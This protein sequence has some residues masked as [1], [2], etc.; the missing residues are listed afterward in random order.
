MSLKRTAILSMTAA[1]VL[2]A[3]LASATGPGMVAVEPEAN[4]EKP[5]AIYHKIVPRDTLWD[6]TEHYLKDPF[7][8]PNVWK[9]NPY[10]RNPHLIYPGNTVKLTPDGI[11]VLGPEDMLAEG[12]EKV[13]LEPGQK[14]TVLEP[15]PGQEAKKPVVEKPVPKGPSVKDHALGRSGFVTQKELD[16]SGA[17]VKPREDK[18]LMTVEDTVF[19]SF[20][21]ASGVRK[22]G[23]YTVYSAGRKIVHPETGK[24]LGYEINILGSLKV[25]KDG[26]TVEAVIDEA[27]KE[28]TPGA[29]VRP[30]SEPVREVEITRAAAEVSGVIVM[31]L[32]GKE[33]LSAGDIAYLDKG[34]VD[35][36]EK[37]NMMRIFRPV[38]RAADPMRSGRSVTLPPLELGTLVVL[39]TGERTATAVVVR[40]LRPINWGDRVSTAEAN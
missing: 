25:T 10:I 26:G 12:L 39:D 33:N 13:G 9:M 20:A 3:G 23:R 34:S 15:E 35:G 40:G 19:L 17:I 1:L 31:A 11:E 30:Y 5:E 37:G 6:I 2:S 16:A 24:P 32:E 38:A 7:K 18:I 29:K 8:W 22:G 4:G 27:F 21:D 36:L 14:V 28:I